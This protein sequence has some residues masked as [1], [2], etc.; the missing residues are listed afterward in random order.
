[1][2]KDIEEKVIDVTGVELTPGKPTVCLG[3]GWQGFECCCDECNYFLICYPEYD[4]KVEKRKP[5][6]RHKIRINRI[7]RERVGST[8][9]PYPE[10]DN[11]YERVRSKLVIKFKIN[12]FLDR[13]R[14]R[15][16]GIY[17]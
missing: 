10:V 14:K 13:R 2:S 15:K 1:M 8:I 5:S 3:N 9:P 12:E 7:F 17:K 6:K 11:L 4:I 16:L